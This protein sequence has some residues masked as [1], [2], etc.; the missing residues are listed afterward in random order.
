MIN[1]ITKNIDYFSQPVQITFANEKKYS[2]IL[3]RILSIIIYAVTL[4]LI[5]SSW[6]NLLNRTNPKTSMTNSHIVDSPIMNLTELKSIYV[7]LFLTK[8]FVPFS[9][10]SYFTIETNQFLVRRYDN[11]TATFDYI[12]LKQVNCSKYYESFKIKGFD[13]DYINNNLDQGVCI[14]SKDLTI[15]G[16]FIGNYFSNFNY[17]INKCTNNTSTNITCKSEQEIN[18]KIKGG[19]FQFFYIDTYVNLNNYSNIFQEYLINYFI[20]LDPN[21][22]KFVEFFFKYVNVSSDLGIVFESNEYNHAVA[23]DYYKDQIDT[24]NTHNLL[25]EFYVNSSKNY[26]FYRRIYMKFQEF[27]ATIGG[28]LKIMTAF[29]YIITRYFTEYEMYEKMFNSLFDFNIISDTKKNDKHISF[30]KFIRNE[31]SKGS[32]FPIVKNL[33]DKKGYISNLNEEKVP[34]MHNNNIPINKSLN[35]KEHLLKLLKGKLDGLKANKKGIKLG[36]FRLI[37]LVLCFCT[38]KQKENWKI[39]N[40]AYFKLTRYLDYL[41]ITQTLQE[42]KRMKKIIFSPVQEKLFRV[43]SKPKI[44]KDMKQNKSTKMEIQN[45]KYTSLYQNYCFIKENNN[46]L[47]NERLLKFMDED[48]KKIFEEIS[49]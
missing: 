22:S 17:I 42:Y 33:V 21:A 13:K 23:F 44:F 14:D 2:T 18:D 7:S 10:P 15:G 40:N 11:G 39:I 25:L 38:R 16:N 27:A 9:D 35:E 5:I 48:Y 29:G 19:F 46:E 20:L 32:Q 43:Y 47:K 36:T 6:N 31:N 26:L 8:D 34:E 49:T 3:G 28:L 37:K 24:S 12:P 45:N 1:W 41:Q 4:A 30:N